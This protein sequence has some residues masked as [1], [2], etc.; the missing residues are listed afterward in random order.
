MARLTPTSLALTAAALAGAIGAA[1]AACEGTQLYMYSAQRYNPAADCVATYAPVETVNGSGASATCP[2]TCLAVGDVLFVSTMCPP[3]P[4]I[5]APVALDAGPCIAA[6]AAVE[7]GRP[8][9]TSAEAGAEDAS[10][11][12][13][14]DGATPIADAGD[15]G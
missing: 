1:L 13:A 15:A 5:A 6:L 9:D 2:P 11:E 10:E 4:S 3:L 7:R 8:C 12:D 14:A